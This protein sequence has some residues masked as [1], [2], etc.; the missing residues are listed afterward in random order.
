MLVTQGDP[1]AERGV[2]PVARLVATEL[3]VERAVVFLPQEIDPDHYLLSDKEGS[4]AE[5]SYADLAAL[6]DEGEAPTALDQLKDAVDAL[7]HAKNDRR[8]SEGLRP[9]ADYYKGYA[10]LQEVTKAG[11]ARLCQ[12][13][14][15]A[16]SGEPGGDTVTSFCEAGLALGL[17]GD[18]LPFGHAL[19]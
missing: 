14:T 17:Y 10:M 19:P 11:L 15:V 12:G 1:A 9:L 6:L 16:H 3:G 13:L 18:P 4:A 8:R 5:V 7:L 2:A